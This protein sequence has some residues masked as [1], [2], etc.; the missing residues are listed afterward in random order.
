MAKNSIEVKPE[1]LAEQAQR[2]LIFS[3]L[4]TRDGNLTRL[5]IIMVSI[6][7]IM[8]I[9]RPDRFPTL[10]NFSSMSFQ[11]SEIGILTI[12]VT[13]AMLTGGID[14]SI[15]AVAN[16]SAILAAIV[17][18]RLIPAEPSSAQIYQ[19]ILL[20]LAVSIVTGILCGLLNGLLIAH[21]GIT[22]ILA[23]L[24]TLTL[25]TGF[26]VVITKGTAVYGVPDQFLY[27]GN[28][29]YLGIPVPLIIF[30]ILALIV[31]IILSRTGF[32]FKIYMIGSNPT[33]S[34]FSGLNN[35]SILVRT[36]V[37]SGLLSALAGIVILARTN[38]SNPDYGGSYV[39]QAILTAVLGGI[40]VSGGFGKVSGLILAIISLQFLSTGLN[41][42][43]FQYS[44]ANFFKEFAWGL[45]LILFM[46]INY[47]S[48]IRRR[49]RVTVAE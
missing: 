31:E 10:Q 30:A 3:R 26:A 33:A 27:L 17:L 22:P 42:L 29:S 32:G 14:L 40:S 1:S 45:L 5:F 43:L 21:V 16:L 44:G 11:L 20:A 24:G 25:F 38:S 15:N 49:M 12:A 39:L 23:T 46:V 34:R 7:V 2:R 48:E 9:A 8:S 6:F 47:L 41:M 18:T 4:V 19:F 13:L 28:G 36:Y 35:R 37:L